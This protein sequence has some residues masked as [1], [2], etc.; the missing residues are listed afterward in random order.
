MYGHFWFFMPHIHVVKET[1]RGKTEKGL[2]FKDNYDS[3]TLVMYCWKEVYLHTE[4]W[5][6]DGQPSSIQSGFRDPSGIKQPVAGSCGSQASG[7]RLLRKESI[8]SLSLSND[9]IV[10]MSLWCP[11]S[12]F[13]WAQSQEGLYWAAQLERE[14][15]LVAISTPSQAWTSPLP[16]S[17]LFLL[18]DTSSVSLVGTYHWLL[19]LVPVLIDVD[20]ALESPPHW[21]PKMNIM[22]YL[23]QP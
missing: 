20:L 2:A 18:W 3:W 17:I 4:T 23:W 16:K 9:A 22:A 13:E 5:I 14:Q 8:F 7:R 19:L 6:E 1:K 21:V 10:P 11:V 12:T 15:D